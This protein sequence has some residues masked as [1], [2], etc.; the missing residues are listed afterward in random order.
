M[1]EDVIFSEIIRALRKRTR[2]LSLTF[3]FVLV[4]GGAVGYWI[5]PVYE[6]ELDVLVHASSS[7]RSNLTAPL[8]GD[9]DTSLRLVETY[10]QIMKS[11][12]MNSK[13]NRELGGR[14]PKT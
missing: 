1:H 2:Q 3:I 5:P 8:M 9:I 7:A 10:K 6:A 13:V 11:D 14:Y 12:R 4:C